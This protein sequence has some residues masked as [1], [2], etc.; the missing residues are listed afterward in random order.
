MDPMLW[1]QAWLQCTSALSSPPVQTDSW[2][3]LVVF[4]H[5]HR[6]VQQSTINVNVNFNRGNNKRFADKRESRMLVD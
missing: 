2:S 6:V 5:P 1:L 3:I 4:S